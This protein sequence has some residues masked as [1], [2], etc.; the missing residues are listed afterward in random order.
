MLRIGID[1]GGT[2]IAAGLV[3]EDYRLLAKKS[4]P[5]GARRPPEEIAAD[6]AELCRSLAAEYG[7][8]L[9]DCGAIGVASPGAVDPEEG[10]ISY[11]SNLPFR[12]YPLARTLSALLD[13]R[14]V[15]LSNDGNAAALGEALAGASR[16][17]K[18]SVMITLGT[19]V[20]GGVILGGKILVGVNGAAAELGHILLREGGLLCSCGRRGCFE[21]YAS[22]TALVRRTRERLVRAI[23][24]GIPTKMLDAVGG[25]PAAVSARTAFTCMR[26]GDAEAKAVV[27]E[28]LCD[29]AA[30][31]TDLVNIFQPEVLSIGGGLSGEGEALLNPLVPLVERDQYTRRSA[32]KT[33]LRI[34]E[35]GNDAG[36]IG[37]A[38]L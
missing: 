24:L 26:E 13:G 27:D 19:G 3:G 30:G 21:A 4:V 29:L 22:A 35:L 2:N 15:R 11:S 33:K 32:K 12:D 8:S 16:G 9:S 18:N 23:A 28:Y 25:D 38:S 31:I 34:A 5:T 10:T 1:L 17:T 14:E 7:V 37:A 6:M 20:G 36:I